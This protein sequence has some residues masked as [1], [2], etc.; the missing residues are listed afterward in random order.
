MNQ[1]FLRGSSSNSSTP[2]A[3]RSLPGG[4][5]KQKSIK[6]DLL[7]DTSSS[8]EIDTLNSTSNQAF[9]FF[10]N[11][12]SIKKFIPN[13]SI[14]NN[15]ISSSS[16]ILNSKP[17]VLLFAL[18]NESNEQSSEQ[19]AQSE[20]VTYEK[21]ELDNLTDIK[22]LNDEE[23]QLNVNIQT[24]KTDYRNDNS[25]TISTLNSNTQKQINDIQSI[26]D[27]KFSANLE[28]Q[29]LYLNFEE[30][31]DELNEIDKCTNYLT[32]TDVI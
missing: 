31:T 16:I 11:D 13:N 9:N 26:R 20:I 2:S 12:L 22:V 1:N 6:N 18:K 15:S 3:A 25:K 27:N 24:N 4:S 5:V 28:D 21:K 32:S 29:T 8:K 10:S 14:T 7:K 17:N 30:S 23:I 19:T